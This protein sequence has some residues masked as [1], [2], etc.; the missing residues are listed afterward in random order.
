MASAALTELGID[1][2]APSITGRYSVGRTLGEGRFSTVQAGTCVRTGA[3]VALKAMALAEVTDDK[4]AREMLVQEVAVLRRANGREHIVGLREVT[5]WVRLFG[6]GVGAGRPHTQH[7]AISP[8][9]VR[10]AHAFLPCGRCSRRPTR[11]TS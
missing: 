6:G 3:E 11:S 1:A 5:L 10:H 4:D 7:S 2:T 9:A 8:A